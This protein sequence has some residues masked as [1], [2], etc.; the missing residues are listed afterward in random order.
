MTVDEAKDAERYRKIKNK[1][2][3]FVVHYY[4]SRIKRNDPDHAVLTPDLDELIDSWEAE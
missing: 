3:P 1:Y 2:S 4:G